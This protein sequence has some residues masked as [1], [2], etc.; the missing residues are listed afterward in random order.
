[1]HFCFQDMWS[2]FSVTV[3]L[4]DPSDS[5]WT[6]TLSPPHL[7]LQWRTCSKYRVP[8]SVDSVWR[9][10]TQ[11]NMLYQPSKV[12]WMEVCQVFCPLF[13]NSVMTRFNL[14]MLCW[15]GICLLFYYHVYWYYSVNK[16]K[17]KQSQ[18]GHEFYK[19]PEHFIIYYFMSLRVFL[20]QSE[21]EAKL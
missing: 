19:T 21:K 7:P 15:Q 5:S 16:R 17:K 14:H 8:G 18:R 3:I 13:F 20:S 12:I 2:S 4:E 11:M 6:G 10:T 1:M 9:A